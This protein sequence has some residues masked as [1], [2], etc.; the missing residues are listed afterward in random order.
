MAPHH[1]AARIG[2]LRQ[3]PDQGEF[4]IGAFAA[5]DDRDPMAEAADMGVT[6]PMV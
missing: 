1:H 5:H 4:G 6:K 3:P 2:G